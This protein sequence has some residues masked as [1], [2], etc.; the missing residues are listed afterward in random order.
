MAKTTDVS[1]D[2]SAFPFRVKV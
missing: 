1:E 2:L